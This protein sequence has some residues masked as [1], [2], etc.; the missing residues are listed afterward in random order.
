MLI[1]RVLG[2]FVFALLLW[3]LSRMRKALHW[4][5]KA[6]TSGS[7][8]HDLS[9]HT[10]SDSMSLDSSRSASYVPSPHGA[11]QSSYPP[12][13]AGGMIEDDTDISICTHEELLVRFESLRHREYV[14]THIYNVSLLERVGMDLKLPTIFHAVGWEKLFE[15]P[16]SGLRL[17]TLKFLT[18]FE[19]FARGR[20]PFVHFCLFRRVQ[21]WLLPI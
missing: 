7:S 6:F 9:S 15:A 21:G 2:P 18:T 4:V 3:V 14:H 10:Q 1:P 17:L 16:Y 5:R 11:G 13:Q 19:S 8:S 20:K 12:A